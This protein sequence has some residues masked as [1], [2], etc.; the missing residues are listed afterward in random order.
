M[1]L[2]VF[3]VV[4]VSNKLR[5]SHSQPHQTRRVEADPVCVMDLVM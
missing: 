2:K 1:L 5:M 3:N 4:L